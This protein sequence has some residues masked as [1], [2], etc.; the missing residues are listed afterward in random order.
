MVPT[1]TSLNKHPGQGPLPWSPTPD[2]DEQSLRVEPRAH[3]VSCGTFVFICLSGQRASGHKKQ[4]E[5]GIG[6]QDKENQGRKRT[7][8]Q[9][10]AE[11]S[12]LKF[13][14]LCTQC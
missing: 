11:V 1:A 5:Q 9:R 7:E 6:K 14:V 13:C 2:H 10:E 4:K 8:L 3:G 12:W